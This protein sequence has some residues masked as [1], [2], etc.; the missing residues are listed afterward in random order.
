M[1]EIAVA[2]VGL[3]IFASVS[4]ISFWKLILGLV[5]IS[6]VAVL[7]FGG[8]NANT[9]YCYEGECDDREPSYNYGR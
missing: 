7:A 4:D 3:F 1:I 5:G 2:L 8:G 6:V 9:E